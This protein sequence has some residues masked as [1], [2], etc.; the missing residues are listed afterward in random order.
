MLHLLRETHELEINYIT[1][2]QNITQLNKVEVY[3]KK[4]AISNF[5]SFSIASYKS[6]L[7]LIRLFMDYQSINDHQGI[8]VGFS[9]LL[10]CSRRN[11]SYKRRTSIILGR[12]KN[13]T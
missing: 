8:S 10:H 1:I 5:S 4:L 2:K 3:N 9:Q 6:S 7:H 11:I 13:K 12:N